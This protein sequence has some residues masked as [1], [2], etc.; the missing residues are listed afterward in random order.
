VRLA[1]GERQLLEEDE[2]AAVLLERERVGPEAVLRRHQ[3]GKALQ[4][5]AQLGLPR[6]R[7]AAEAE[8]ED[9]C[10]T[11]SAFCSARRAMRPRIGRGST[12]SG[13][14]PPAARP[15]GTA[16]ASRGPSGALAQ[17][18]VANSAVLASSWRGC[19]P[20]RSG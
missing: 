3:A 7:F 11:C 2:V 9:H 4:V 13:R 8:G 6:A 20:P 12:R 15:R 5:G 16:R 17:A 10:S 14:R 19:A 18:R 1:R